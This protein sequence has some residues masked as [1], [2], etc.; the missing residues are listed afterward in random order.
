MKDIFEEN[1]TRK[2]YGATKRCEE[3][4]QGDDN[5]N[6][7][8]A[9]RRKCR[10]WFLGRAGGVAAFSTSRTD[11]IL[12]TKLSAALL[13][14]FSTDFP[15]SRADGIEDDELSSLSPTLGAFPSVAIDR[16]VWKT[17]KN[18]KQYEQ[19]VKGKAHLFYEYP[20]DKRN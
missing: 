7:D 13:S 5:N 2:V 6:E 17:W 18:S 1:K 8:L 11:S 19:G 10:V 16:Y 12:T 15:V 20:S 4:N 3:T 14:P 9:R